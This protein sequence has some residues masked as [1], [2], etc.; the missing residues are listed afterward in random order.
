MNLPAVWKE[1]FA[2]PIEELQERARQ[3]WLT[4]KPTERLIISVLAAILALL[5]AILIVKEAF[6]FFSRH[7][8]QVQES[9]EN[10]NE[11]QKLSAEIS[12]QRMNLRE[13]DRLKSRRGET[14]KINS[15]LET[16]GQRLGVAIEKV[17]PTKSRSSEKGSDEEWYEI[18]LGKNTTLDMAIRYLQAVQEPLGVRLIDLSMK[19]QFTDPTHLEVIAV[20]AALKEIE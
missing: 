12:D 15:F 19:P 5:T 20:I 14:F 17:S 11:I 8:T 9:L 18:K 4:L 2:E 13:Y 3:Q 1:K 16:E 7:E 6:T 10:I